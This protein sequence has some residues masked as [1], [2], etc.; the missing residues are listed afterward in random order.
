[1]LIQEQNQRRIEFSYFHFFSKDWETKKVP[2][3]WKYGNNTIVLWEKNT[4]D[5]VFHSIY[6]KEKEKRVVYR[7]RFVI[8]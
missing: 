8:R 5:D 4:M 3:H 2:Y 6:Q 7:Y 1:M